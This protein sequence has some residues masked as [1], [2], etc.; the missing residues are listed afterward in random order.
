MATDSVKILSIVDKEGAG[1]SDHKD[2]DE[3]AFSP[4]KD[5]HVACRRGQSGEDG[6]GSG[7][8]HGLFPTLPCE[9][10]RSDPLE[11]VVGSVQMGSRSRDLEK[12]ASWG[13]TTGQGPLGG[14]TGHILFS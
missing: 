4:Q 5:H 1:H 13:S 14:R 6:E 9:A 10:F 7:L 3:N 8:E 11:A 12:V 2:H